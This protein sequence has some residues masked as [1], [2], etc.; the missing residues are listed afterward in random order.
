MLSLLGLLASC[1]SPQEDSFDDEPEEIQPGD[2]YVDVLPTG[3][4]EG[5]ILH[6]FDWKYNDIKDNL[7]AIKDAGYNTIQTSPVQQPKSG[8]AQWQFFY[9]PV[10]FSIATSSPL[11]TKEELQE[12]CTSAHERGMFIISDIV[13]NHLGTTGVNNANGLPEVEPEVETYEP[14]I[15]QHQDECFHQFKASDVSGLG[16]V[17]Q[18]YDGLP[19]L[20]TG[21]PHVQERALSL[22]KECIDVGIDGFRFDA[23]KHIETPTDSEYASSF[24]DNTL[25]VAKT[26]YQEKRG[27]QLFAYGEILNEVDGNRDISAYTRYM[28]VTENSYVGSGVFSAV[29]SSKHDA[30]LAVKAKYGKNTS[31]SNLITWVESHDTYMTD[32][33][34][35]P[36][37]RMAKLWAII[38]SRKD[39]QPLY[40]ARTDAQ[41]TVGIIGD[42]D[43]EKETIAISNRFHN[44]FLGAEEYQH[45][46]ETTIYINERYSETDCGALICDLKNLKTATLSFEHLEDGYYFDQFTNKQIHIR[47]G[48]GNIEFGDM[49]V[50]ILTKTNNPLRAEISVSKTSGKYFK[51]FD[52]NVTL[53]NATACSYSIN[54]GEAVSFINSTSIR[55][56]EGTSEGEITK[57]KIDFTNGIFASSR[58][59][60][61]TKLALIEGY[62]NIINFDASYID[63]Y[64]LYLWTWDGNSSWYNQNYTYNREKR[65]LLVSN[66]EHLAGFLL[67]IFEKGT[68]ISIPNKWQTPLKQSSDITPSSMEYFD[69]SSF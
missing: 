16:Y 5:V 32:T 7:D 22:L 30:S 45:A 26:Y 3:I 35:Q 4:E 53:T 52:L 31:A 21:N 17:T 40:F 14:Y 10:S 62:F 67:A 63:D 27:R 23:A 28:K 57:V 9:Q 44:R 56:G 51:P 47:N 58:T 60:L 68:T 11:G 65:I 41:K 43:Y 46:E 2:G 15:Y 19:D 55:I 34:H 1:T 18:Y 33:A 42:Y 59:Y 25:E 20:N 24:W 61:F 64:T 39:T 54:D 36:L 38:A 6:A 49:G 13:F 66:Y 29:A 50:A 48:K 12:L 8:G 69:A 37:V